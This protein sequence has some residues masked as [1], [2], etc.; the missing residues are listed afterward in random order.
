MELWEN[1]EGN[2]PLTGCLIISLTGLTHFLLIEI[3]AILIIQEAY[4]KLVY[5]TRL[6]I[7]LLTLRQHSTEQYINKH[8]TNN[9]IQKYIHRKITQCKL[10]A[11][12]RPYV[13]NKHFNWLAL[14]MI[15][16][17]NTQERVLKRTRRNSFDQYHFQLLARL[18]R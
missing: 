5:L 11:G 10:H 6:F 14:N 7:A 3:R 9:T 12:M 16:C 13:H 2:Q 4:Y 1:A 15:Q 8:N 18:N 17:F